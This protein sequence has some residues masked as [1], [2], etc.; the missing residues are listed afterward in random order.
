MNDAR[1]VDKNEASTILFVICCGYVL[2]R[3]Q[4]LCLVMIT[5]NKGIFLKNAPDV[6]Y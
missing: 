3:K 5:V 4:L 6:V 2:E 1:F